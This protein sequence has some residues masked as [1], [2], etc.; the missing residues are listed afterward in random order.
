MKLVLATIMLSLCSLS[1]AQLP[2][3]RSL[4]DTSEDATL[5]SK[6]QAI[7]AA[8]SSPLADPGCSFLFTS[9]AN[10]TFSVIASRATVT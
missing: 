7:N 5:L 2:G 4:Q 3:A 6:K 1:W 9:G 8:R 10:N